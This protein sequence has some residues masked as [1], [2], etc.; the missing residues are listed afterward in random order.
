MAFIDRHHCTSIVEL[1]TIVWCTKDGDE[2]S[3]CEEFVAIFNNLVCTYHKIHVVLLQESGYHIR[4][5]DEG[6]A[7][8]V[9]CPACNVLVWVGPQKV[10]DQ[11]RVGD[12]RG[13][14]QTTHLVK[15]VDF[16]RKAAMHAHDLLV[17]EATNR[18]AIEDVA[19]L[20]PHL[21]VVPAFTLV[22]EA[23]DAGD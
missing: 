12:V 6:D 23:I 20:L 7:T 22:I 21:D 8:I 9:F 16:R 4:P 18:H 5:K 2:L 17:N 11:A 14:H 3:L 1:T 19:E 10:A 13:A 15:V